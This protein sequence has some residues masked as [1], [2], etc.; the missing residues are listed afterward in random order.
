MTVVTS[1]PGAGAATVESTIDLSGDDLGLSTALHIREA[2]KRALDEGATHYTTR[3]GLD[4]LRQAVAEKLQRVNG[5]TVDAQREVLI[6]CGTQE[7]LF[8][9][10]HLL[11]ER[12]DE[13]LIPQ[14]AR[15]AYA[16][17]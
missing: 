6:T 2:A 5:V 15:P 9:A 10:L 3:P 16:A 14:P 12:G 8:V 11:L 7:A 1:E 13:V 4:P 17:I